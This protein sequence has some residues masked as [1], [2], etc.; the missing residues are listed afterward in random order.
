MKNGRGRKKGHGRE[1]KNWAKV[2]KV[3]KFPGEQIPE[4]RLD[5]P[6]KAN[7]MGFGPVLG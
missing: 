4:V 7:D 5:L 1:Y 6:E 3:S 2:Y